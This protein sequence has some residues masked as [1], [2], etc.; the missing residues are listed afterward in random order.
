MTIKLWEVA[1]KSF[2]DR[3]PI[4]SKRLVIFLDFMLLLNLCHI[5]VLKDAVAK[6]KEILQSYWH[7]FR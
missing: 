2:R 1:E 6:P 3:C 5:V 7:K 4:R